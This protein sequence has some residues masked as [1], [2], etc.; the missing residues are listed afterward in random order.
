MFLIN[1]KYNKDYKSATI[2]SS[3]ISTKC[4]TYAKL[5]S[6]GRGRHETKERK[7]KIFTDEAG[8]F[9]HAHKHHK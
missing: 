4:H 2:E 7:F 9:E 3:S 5:H 6:C 1:R 8:S